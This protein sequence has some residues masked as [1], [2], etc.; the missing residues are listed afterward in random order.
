[1]FHRKLFAEWRL[2]SLTLLDRQGNLTKRINRFEQGKLREKDSFVNMRLV[3]V[4]GDGVCEVLGFGSIDGMAL[5]RTSQP[6]IDRSFTF[7]TLEARS[8]IRRSCLKNAIRSLCCHRRI[9][10]GVT[11]FW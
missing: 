7:T 11:R 10:A 2:R 3:D 1:M 6:S 5:S 8:P 4:E 9:A